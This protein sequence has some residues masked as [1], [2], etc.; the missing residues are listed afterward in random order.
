M[1]AAVFPGLSCLARLFFCLSV[2]STELWL[3]VKVGQR[4][5]GIIFDLQRAELVRILQCKKCL[6]LNMAL[7]V[8]PKPLCR[9][10]LKEYIFK[11]NQS[12]CKTSPK[13]KFLLH[14]HFEC[15]TQC[16]I[17]TLWSKS[18]KDTEQQLPF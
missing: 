2:H 10:F 18:H 7:V 5:F 4:A 17:K 8:L 1:F 3:A 13:Y 9:L 16:I 14:F 12:G 15:Q 11:I 6:C